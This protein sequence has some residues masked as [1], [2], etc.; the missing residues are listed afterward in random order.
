MGLPQTDAL[1]DYR[2]NGRKD[3]SGRF[4]EKFREWSS[5]K[6]SGVQS[7]CAISRRIGA[8]AT[9]T[10]SCISGDI[11]VPPRT[12]NMADAAARVDISGEVIGRDQVITSYTLPSGIS[13]EK[14]N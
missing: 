12:I 6:V 9:L 11:A 4:D 14:A 10:A 1:T 3:T 13:R 5:A 7:T 8:E 2:M